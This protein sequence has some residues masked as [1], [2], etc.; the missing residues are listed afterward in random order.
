MAILGGS[1]PDGSFAFFDTEGEAAE[2]EPESLGGGLALVHG[3]PG[4][5]AVLR[6]VPQIA[7]STESFLVGGLSSPEAA[8]TQVAGSVTGGGLSGVLFSNEV[9]AATALSQG[10]SPIGP[11]RAITECRDNVAIKIDGRPALEVFRED[12]GEEFADDLSRAGGV[13]FVAFP[14]KGS[15]TAD[16]MV[17]NLVG[18]DEERQLLGIGALLDEHRSILFCRRDA[19]SARADLARM[20]KGLH[21]R[22]GDAPAGGIY[23]SC[24][25]RGPNL[26][27][28]GS[29][30]LKMIEAELGDVPLVGFFGSG[31]ISHDRLYTQT[32]ILTLFL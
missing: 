12:I 3:D 24:V 4:G 26:F 27:G 1:F 14:V 17:R 29:E 28:P 20:L 2:P 16:Y 32:G 21:G 18:V 30:E 25:A 6:L 8:E 9:E 10:C 13:I 7:Q 23:A 5:G 22:A 15:D 11:V 31:E 19:D